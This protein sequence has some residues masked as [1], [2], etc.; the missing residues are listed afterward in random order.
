MTLRLDRVPMADAVA[1]RTFFEQL[2]SPL[3]EVPSLGGMRSSP[4]VAL[5][6]APFAVALRNGIAAEA[7][8]KGW[9]AFAFDLQNAIAADLVV[10]GDEIVASRAFGDSSAR[11]TVEAIAIAED[12]AG[13][14]QDVEVRILDIPSLFF[15]GV[16]VLA[17]QSRC[18]EIHD[19][20]GPTVRDAADLFAELALFAEARLA[21]SETAAS[22]LKSP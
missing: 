21:A 18:I 22:S 2:R 13:S 9:R 5:W 20:G 15:T 10:A 14:E 6:T 16:W 19:D 7:F 4:A 1:R 8:P 11:A 17:A 12:L 3:L